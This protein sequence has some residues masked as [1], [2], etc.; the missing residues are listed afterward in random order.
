MAGTYIQTTDITDMILNET[1]LST[2]L[3]AKV[4]ASDDAVED[5]A[6]SKG[7]EVDDIETD[8]VH[9]LV[10]RYAI[11]WVGMELCFDALGKNNVEIA[12]VEKY[13]IKYRHYKEMVKEFAERITSSMLNGSTS[14][15]MDRANTISGVLFRN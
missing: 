3:S 12:D 9:Y 15:Q 2:V 6:E 8:P 13:H 11:A 4:D 7:V 14:R 5:L 10:K 1:G